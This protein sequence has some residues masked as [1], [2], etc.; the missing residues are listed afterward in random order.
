M[1]FQPKQKLSININNSINETNVHNLVQG[2]NDTEDAKI[3][4]L[5]D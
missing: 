1:S 5:S 2:L 3:I 4:S